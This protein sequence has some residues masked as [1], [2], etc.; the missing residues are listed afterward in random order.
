MRKI[1]KEE[2]TIP[3]AQEDWASNTNIKLGNTTINNCK[4]TKKAIRLYLILFRK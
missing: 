1:I 3:V 4:K 2:A